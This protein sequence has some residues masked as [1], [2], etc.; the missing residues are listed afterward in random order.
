MAL[1]LALKHGRDRSQEVQHF[2]PAHNLQYGFQPAG[3]QMGQ[4]GPDAFGEDLLGMSHSCQHLPATSQQASPLQFLQ[5]A[6]EQH[7]SFSSQ[8]LINPSP[9]SSLISP[10]ST[11][12]YLPPS[13]DLRDLD[14][15]LMPPSRMHEH[16][17]D[18]RPA[19]GSSQL[20]HGHTAWQGSHGLSQ[21][22]PQ[23]HAFG[24]QRPAQHQS[25]A[26]DP[27]PLARWHSHLNTGGAWSETGCSPDMS[28]MSQVGNSCAPVSSGPQV[29]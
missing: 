24:H 23:T 9:L 6:P 16:L 11:Q 28:M 12:S 7:A 20:M 14:L 8:D 1:N 19:W 26:M 25:M 3:D 13:G 18:A 2:W 15:D 22:A 29:L 5:Q 21:S 27:S 10:N 17:P 4:P